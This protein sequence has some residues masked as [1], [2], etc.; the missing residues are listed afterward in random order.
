MH[1][2]TTLATL[3]EETTTLGDQLRNFESKICPSYR[4]HELKREAAARM[5]RQGAAKAGSTSSVGGDKKDREP[6]TFNLQ[7]YKAHSL[8][9]YV[10]TIRNFGTTDSYSSQLVSFHV[11][12]HS[13]SP[14]I[15]HYY[16]VNSNI[17]ALKHDT[18]EPAKRT[19]C[20]N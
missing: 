10:A 20:D 3:D 18:K 2:D 4:T 19:S 8:G 12:S 5:R 1:T 7:T 13:R 15:G 11:P 16:R 17:K 14:S 6:K 9:D